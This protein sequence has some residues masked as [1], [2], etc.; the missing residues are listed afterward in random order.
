MRFLLAVLITLI[1]LSACVENGERAGVKAVF[2]KIQPRQPVT[3]QPVVRAPLYEVS[4]ELSFAKPVVRIEEKKK[5][6]NKIVQVPGLSNAGRPGEPLLPVKNL[7]FVVPAGKVFD[8]IEVVPGEPVELGSGFDVVFGEE[9]FNHFVEAKPSVKNTNIYMSN[10]PFPKE[11]YKVHPS[12]VW[13]GYEIIPI[14]V[15]PVRYYP[16]SGKLVYYPNLKVNVKFRDA[17]GKKLPRT[18][19]GL[20]R[21]KKLVEKFVENKNDVKAYT[22][23]A[24]ITGHAIMAQNPSNIGYLI[25]ASSDYSFIFNNLYVYRHLQG[26]DA[27]GVVNIEDILTDPDVD[28]AVELRNFILN[29]YLSGVDYVLL[30]GD[31]DKIPYRNLWFF[32]ENGYTYTAPSDLYFSGL[33]GTW[34]N[35]NDGIY[36]E[37]DPSDYNGAAQAGGSAGEEADFYSEVI[38]GRVPVSNLNEAQ[39][40]LDKI[41]NYESRPDTDPYLKKALIVGSDLG[42]LECSC[43]DW[44]K[45]LISTYI[46]GYDVERLYECPYE[47][48]DY[49]TTDL[50]NALNNGV[51]IVNEASHGDIG[52]WD[53]FTIGDIS[54]LTNTDYFFVYSWACNTADF[55]YEDSF[56]EKMVTDING[57][58]AYIG[59]TALGWYSSGVVGSTSWRFDEAFFKAI[60]S[61]RNFTLGSAFVS[62]KENHINPY[63]H[64][65]MRW[66]WFG[67][68]LL[69]DPLTTIRDPTSCGDGICHGFSGENSQNCPNDCANCSELYGLCNLYDYDLVLE[70]GEGCYVDLGSSCESL[71]TYFDNRPEPWAAQWGSSN[72]GWHS[73]VN[74]GA[75]FGGG[76]PFVM[77]PVVDTKN[78]ATGNA[79]MCNVKFMQYDNGNVGQASLLCG[80]GNPLV[81][82][83]NPPCDLDCDQDLY[84]NNACEADPY[85]SVDPDCTFQQNSKCCAYCGDGVCDVSES[86]YPSD[87]DCLNNPGVVPC[88]CAADCGSFP[89]DFCQDSDDSNPTNRGCVGTLN[90]TNNTIVFD[91]CLNSDILIEKT[92]SGNASSSFQYNCT[93]YAYNYCSAG[94]CRT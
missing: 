36:G 45:E 15:F 74:E 56:A 92:C 2:H 60:F 16:L 7:R 76:S 59:N 72:G 91:E 6:N 26:Y 46:D 85:C 41:I 42:G 20:D 40:W 53:H 86:K 21:D 88:Y 82:K 37:A 50:V 55:S 12:G 31:T 68:N 84:C 5:K 47:G 63:W 39:N 64:A 71:E 32:T 87:P 61:D 80:G 57:P 69:G 43:A 65:R 38:I 94:R 77:K 51:Y 79:V 11:F 13:R 8:H 83:G 4:S 23:F 17:P 27:R 9:E 14:S 67:L 73:T 90:N 44:G 78:G 10:N 62:S 24:R 93:Q 75:F 48:L 25:I 81:M 66:V 3:S 58:F 29:Q 49:G 52:G 18:F 34:D 70:K 28:D 89:P 1:F 54:S 19:R 30:A 33:D 35:D 22:D